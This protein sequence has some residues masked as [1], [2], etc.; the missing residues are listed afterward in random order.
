MSQVVAESPETD[1][2]AD[3]KSADDTGE[4]TGEPT[5]DTASDDTAGDAAAIE[6]NQSGAK[7]QKIAADDAASSDETSSDAE[8]AAGD[9]VKPA[10]D[11]APA[12]APGTPAAMK[13][14]ERKRKRAAEQAR[15]DAKQPVSPH[16]SPHKIG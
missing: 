4:S 8:E 7:T 10:G 6:D 1:T 16:K 11:A 14:I 5:G 12:G 13:E 2:P 15:F 9:T 3:A